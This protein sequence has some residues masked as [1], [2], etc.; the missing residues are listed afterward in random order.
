MTQ[1]FNT[2][3]QIAACE[4]VN[5]A[6]GIARHFQ[7]Q[8]R[9]AFHLFPCDLTLGES[10]LHVDQHGG[11][12]ALVNAMGEYDYNNMNLVRFL[13]RDGGTFVDVG[14]NIGSYTLIASENPKARV[15]SIEPHPATFALLEANVFKNRRMNVKCLNLALSSRNAE[16]QL[17][18]GP[19]TS[20]NHLV[21][22][23]CFSND[24]L[25]VTSR[26]YESLF[27]EMGESPNFLKI[28]VEGHE[29][30]VLRG[31]GG[32]A[33]SLQIILVEGGESDAVRSWMTNWGFLGPLYVHASR[34]IF[35][36]RPQRRAEDPIYVKRQ[37]LN[38]CAWSFSPNG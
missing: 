6:Q 20:V 31:V 36:S 38:S 18:D 1:F 14:A 16:V 3:G 23:D 26:K 24:T 12:A 27:S 37:F 19:E 34:R 30:E 17:T 10:R 28:D 13:L 29:L 7:W 33:N 2:L 4:S 22:D 35:S 21:G 5:T 25:T 9:R 11:V 8:F 32:L 15:I